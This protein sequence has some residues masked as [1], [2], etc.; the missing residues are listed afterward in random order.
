MSICHQRP[1]EGERCSSYFLVE[2]TAMYGKSS[3]EKTAEG[4]SLWHWGDYDT[5]KAYFTIRH[6]TKSG[7]I[8]L[9]N[10]QNGRSI[11]PQILAKTLGGEQPASLRPTL[12]G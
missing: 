8:Y 2:R 9:T 1:D 10:S 6:A 5:F 11:G 7:V 4:M 3:I 12:P